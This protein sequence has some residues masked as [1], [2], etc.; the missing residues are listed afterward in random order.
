[1]TENSADIYA[2]WRKLFSRLQLLAEHKS[3]GASYPIE[4]VVYSLIFGYVSGYVSTILGYANIAKWGQL[5]IKYK[6]VFIY[7]K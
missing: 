4:D 5:L 2:I 3:I 7:D 1:M 6:W